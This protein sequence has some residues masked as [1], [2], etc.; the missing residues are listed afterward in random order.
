MRWWVGCLVGGLLACFVCACLGG[1]LALV[2]AQGGGAQAFGQLRV[3]GAARDPVISAEAAAS[4]DRKVTEFNQQLA[5]RGAQPATVTLTADEVSSRLATAPELNELRQAGFELVR[6]VVDFRDNRAH[7]AGQV[8]MTDGGQTFGV[9]GRLNA[10]PVRG[11]N[12]VRFDFDELNLVGLLPIP[13]PLTGFINNS[14]PAADREVELPFILESIQMA[15][16]QLTIVARP[17]A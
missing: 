6:L 4:F 5:R 12:A 10:V 1:G 9:T 11:G 15:N 3:P 8:R 2:A 13:I 7:F 17:K 14:I 16:G